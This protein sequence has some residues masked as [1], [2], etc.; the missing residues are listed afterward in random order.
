[1]RIETQIER[2]ADTMRE[3][4]TETERGTLSAG[5]IYVTNIDQ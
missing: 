5:V 2:Q 1:M 4:Q 3:T